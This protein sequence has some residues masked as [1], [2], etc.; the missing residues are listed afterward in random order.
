MSP[1]GSKVLPP[2]A[3]ETFR[4]VYTFDR[5]LVL[6]GN[7][8]QRRP[9]RGERAMI[10]VDGQLPAIVI[11]K[12]PS[13]SIGL[14]PKTRHL[15]GGHRFWGESVKLTSRFYRKPVAD[16]GL[17]NL[18]AKRSSGKRETSRQG[19]SIVILCHERLQYAVPRVFSW[20]VVTESHEG[21]SGNKLQ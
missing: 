2:E 7:H 3:E 21:F 16:V 20:L 5:E 4:H 8:S 13:S 9:N 18:R 11:E 17:S 6:L 12:A 15:I 14:C 10:A 1:Q 19:S